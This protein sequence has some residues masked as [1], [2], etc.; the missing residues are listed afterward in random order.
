M[1]DWRAR[2][3]EGS[4]RE[5]PFLIESHQLTGGR[6]KQDRE[7]AKRDLGNSEDLGRR[8]K[9]F[10]LSIFVLG[11]DY[12]DQRDAL[13][14]ALETE[15][16]GILI[17]PYLGTRIVQ[18]GNY[19]LSETVDEGR[20]AKFSVEFT[21]AGEAKFPDQVEDDLNDEVIDRTIEESKNV[22][23]QIF[24]V[25]NQAAQVVQ[26]AA[27]GVSAVVDFM[28][29]AVKKVTEPLANMTFAIRNLKADVN[30][31]LT[32][33]GELF[34]RMLGMFNTLLDEFSD[35]PDTASRI[36]GTFRNVDDSFTP[37][38]GD[39]PSREKQRG[40][41]DATIGMAKQLALTGNARAVID[42]DFP[43]TNAALE[44]QR[45]IVEGLD[46]QLGD[47][48]EL[49]Q[50]IKDLQTALNKALPRVGTTELLE[51]TPAQTIPALVIAH[52]EFEDLDKEDEII[53]QNAIEHPGF[54]PGGDPILVSA[55]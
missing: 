22:F 7:F 18:A 35:D 21:E 11:D 1:A 52:S 30:D 40:N 47:D 2:Y 5:V 10:T 48:D 49:F 4:F 46:E 27:D 53:D 45:E 28:D 34:D 37:V 41:Q 17:H 54:V 19:T 33:P 14:E 39:T 15:G 29:N 42:I 8:L 43:S 55:G 6:R 16:S 3:R 24:D 32:R 31:L 44:K 25:A 50:A 23:E 38:L 13:I 51:I 20:I 12:F 9:K 26:A 36:L